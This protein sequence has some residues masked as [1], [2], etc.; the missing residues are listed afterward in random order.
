MTPENRLDFYFDGLPVGHFLGAD[1]PT[2]AGRY[3]YDPYRGEGHF[4][5][6]QALKHG[7]TECFYTRKGRVYYL[8]IAAEEFTEGR[9]ECQ[10]FVEVSEIQACRRLRYTLLVAWRRVGST[11]RRLAMHFGDSRLHGDQGPP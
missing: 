11:L 7:V 1:Y 3:P 2:E 8:L 6:V 9:P 5:L 10:W 4:R